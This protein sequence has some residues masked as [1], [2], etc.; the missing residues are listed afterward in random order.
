MA[1]KGPAV[2]VRPVVL[3]SDVLIWYLRGEARAQTYFDSIPH[4]RRSLFAVVQMELTRGCRDSGELRK[5]KGFF[6]SEFGTLLPISEEVSRRA[7]ALV[8][9]YGLSHDL[10]PDDALIAAAALTTRSDLGTANLADY[11]FI[12]GLRLLP[13][14]PEG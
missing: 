2:P 3:D 4:S 8:S 12:S 11:R 10:A 13:F 7:V 9:R 6:S 14:S 5:L 1:P